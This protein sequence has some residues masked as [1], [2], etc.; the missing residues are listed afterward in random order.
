MQVLGG[1]ANSRLNKVLR[2]EKGWSY[3]IGAQSV[4]EKDRNNSLLYVSTT[5]QADHTEASIAEI[6]KIIAELAT[7]PVTDEEF[8][9]A[10]RTV[11]A[12]FLNA[13]ESAPVM[14]SFAASMAS[15]EYALK[16]LQEYLAEL[17]T[18]TLA[19][20]NAQAAVIAKS[21]IALSI[22]GDKATMK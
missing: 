14:A 8:Q 22:A 11:R 5:V 18:V 1:D 17:D 13:F 4:G 12:Q 21:P 3:G 7:K 20:V 19:Q 15:Q 16:D 10:K 2:E 6:R 9:S